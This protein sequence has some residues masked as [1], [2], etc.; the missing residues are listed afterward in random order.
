MIASERGFTRTSVSLEGFDE[1]ARGWPRE[2]SAWI[3]ALRGRDVLD[4]ISA[5]AGP[6][7]PAW[8]QAGDLGMP[9]K[10]RWTTLSGSS[11]DMPHQAPNQPRR[12]LSRV[13]SQGACSYHRRAPFGT[14]FASWI[15]RVR[16]P[17]GGHP[18][19][20]SITSSARASSEDGTSRPIVLAVCR[21]MTNSNFT[22]RRM[23]RSAGF[24]PLRMRPV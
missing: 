10:V 7:R 4:G 20:H 5:Q 1:A 12:V 19:H 18:P 11:N 8:R 22:A 17:Q 3:S 13:E 15:D 6:P 23:G 9:T 14:F 21:L 2:F 16:A 24:S